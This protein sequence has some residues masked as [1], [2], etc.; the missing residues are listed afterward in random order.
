[1]ETLHAETIE[2]VR[3]YIRKAV[4]FL[5]LSINSKSSLL[6]AKTYNKKL[7]HHGMRTEL[8]KD[9]VLF[10]ELGGITTKEQ[11]RLEYSPDLLVAPMLAQDVSWIVPPIEEGKIDILRGN[12]FMH[13]VE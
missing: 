10:I 13:R 4:H 6:K 1:M 7:I 2:T 3:P 5:T 12:S 8:V 9:L 11:D